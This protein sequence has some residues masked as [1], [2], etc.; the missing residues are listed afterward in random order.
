ME[1]RIVPTTLA[2]DQSFDVLRSRRQEELLANKLHSAQTQATEAD[3]ILEFGK[4]RLHLSSLPLRVGEGRS[5]D[6]V[7]SALPGRLMDMN[8]EILVL[9]SRALRLL[10]ARTD[11]PLPT[12]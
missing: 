4:E 3:L 5:V 2:T 9:A 10:R 6:K 11:F 7:A 1:T 12:G 8:G